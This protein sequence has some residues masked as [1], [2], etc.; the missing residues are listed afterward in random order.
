MTSTTAAATTF[1]FSAPRS[2]SGA[3]VLLK[4][5]TGAPGRTLHRTGTFWGLPLSS[6]LPWSDK[7]ARVQHRYRSN[8]CRVPAAEP[9]L[10]QLAEPGLDGSDAP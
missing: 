10:N 2:Y 5:K 7:M 8:S 1:L 6:V 3:F 9:S 4:I